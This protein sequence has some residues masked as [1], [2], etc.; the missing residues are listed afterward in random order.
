MD[1]SEGHQ[2]HSKFRVRVHSGDQSPTEGQSQGQTSPVSKIP[3]P[4]KKTPLKSYQHLINPFGSH[5]NLH[6][7]DDKHHQHDHFEVSMVKRYRACC[8]FNGKKAVFK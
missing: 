3:V 7:H 1:R 4:M 6:H 5:E 2:G 8:E